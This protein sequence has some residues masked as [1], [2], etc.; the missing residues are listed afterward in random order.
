MSYRGGAGGGALGPYAP[1]PGSAVSGAFTVP[2]ARPNS[3]ERVQPTGA[4]D[5]Q[6]QGACIHASSVN[7]SVQGALYSAAR[8][9]PLDVPMQAVSLKNGIGPPPAA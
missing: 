8:P 1:A 6:R 4:E 7:T 5:R 2:P 9:Q 3:R